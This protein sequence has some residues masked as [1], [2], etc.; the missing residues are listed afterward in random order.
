L[1]FS[2]QGGK[3]RKWEGIPATFPLSHFPTI[4]N[5]SHFMAGWS[6]QYIQV[7][8]LTPVDVPGS[9]QNIHRMFQIHDVL[10]FDIMTKTI[11]INIIIMQSKAGILSLL[12]V[13][14][15]S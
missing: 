3:V 14:V 10:L 8:M 11:I 7:S 1:D 5:K 13:I 9:T 2:G 12:Q 4:I 6:I 15:F